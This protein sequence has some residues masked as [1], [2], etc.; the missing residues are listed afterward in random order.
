MS[1]MK[2]GQAILPVALL[3]GSGCAYVGEPLPPALNIPRPVTAL[4]AEQV[5]SRIA[6]RFELPAQTTEALA[7]EVRAIELR[8]GAVDPAAW[9][10]YA[11]V[12][13]ATRDSGGKSASASVELA[14]WIGKRIVAGVRVQSKQ[15]KWSAW[16]PL[17][18]V[19]VVEPL[20][21][22]AEVKTEAVAEGV[23]IQWRNPARAGVSMRIE[24]RTGTGVVFVEAGTLDAAAAEWIDQ[25][26]RFGE[27]QRYRLT[28]VAGNKA[29][30]ETFETKAFTP[31]D[32][33]APGVPAGLS[34][35]T[36]LGSVELS[37]DRP[38]E[39]DLAG[40]RVYRATGALDQTWVRVSPAERIAAAN[41][42]DRTVQPA[43]AYRYSVTSVDQ[44]GNE[45]ARSQP[46]EITSPN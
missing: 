1:E 12:V 41:F 9:P 44:S 13:E 46:V 42:S 38:G 19:D 32:R 43:T 33:F 45:S 6:M 31:E 29:R 8:A 2:V 34:A 3:F 26:A 10:G 5:G 40:F 11:Q 30:S 4:M 37:W 35:V 24:R 7:L 23:R 36:G 25:Q 20:A 14:P 22:P 15:G 27:E 17:A 28:A 21:A 18:P 39:A 16:S